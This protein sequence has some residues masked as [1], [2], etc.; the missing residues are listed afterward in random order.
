MRISDINLWTLWTYSPSALKEIMDKRGYKVEYDS[1]IQIC[2]IP[3]RSIPFDDFQKIMKMYI[4]LGY[5][6]W[7]RADYRGGYI[8]SKEQ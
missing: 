2:I 1:D 4:E 8:L 6:W 7:H 5:I 3:N